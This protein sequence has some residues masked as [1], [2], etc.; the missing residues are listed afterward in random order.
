M[1]VELI[2]MSDAVK[3]VVVVR[4]WCGVVMV[5]CCGGGVVVCGRGSGGG[6]RRVFVK[7]QTGAPTTVSNKSVT[8]LFLQQELTSLHS[9]WH[10][11]AQ[12]QPPNNLLHDVSTSSN[13][14]TSHGHTHTMFH[15][16]H[17]NNPHGH[18]CS[19]SPNVRTHI[20]VVATNPDTHG[21]ER[22]NTQT[23]THADRHEHTH[24]N[25]RTHTPTYLTRTRIQN[26]RPHIMTTHTR[27]G[28]SRALAMY[29]SP[30]CARKIPPALCGRGGLGCA[31]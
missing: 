2:F 8:C 19:S 11:L 29:S 30:F 24:A 23:R 15:P 17:H 31:T 26:H 3:V 25:T 27:S 10:M 21:H 7:Q 4:L 14:E 6:R 9:R 13:R 1:G 20:F 12:E 22:T 18:Q 16:T 28:R 5:Q